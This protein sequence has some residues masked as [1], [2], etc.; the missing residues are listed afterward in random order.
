MASLHSLHDQRG[1][2]DVSVLFSLGFIG[3]TVDCAL[4]RHIFRSAQRRDDPRGRAGTDVLAALLAL[5]EVELRPR[6]DVQGG[7]ETVAVDE[8]FDLLH[9]E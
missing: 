9:D 6:L 4:F 2:L 1:P 7:D 5:R 3:N 8:G